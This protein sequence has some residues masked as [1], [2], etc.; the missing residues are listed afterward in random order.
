MAKMRDMMLAGAGMLLSAGLLTQVAQP[1]MAAETAVKAFPNAQLVRL[2]TLG[3][4][5]M[6][7]DPATFHAALADALKP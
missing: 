1:A 4:S 6:V 5:P 2:D 7:E 3:H